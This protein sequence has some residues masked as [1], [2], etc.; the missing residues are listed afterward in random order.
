MSGSSKG[1][2][3]YKLCR[4]PLPDAS[5]QVSKIIGLL[6]LEKKGFKCFAIYSH[7]GHLGH[8]T[9]TIYIN[10]HCPF[11]T[12]LNISF[13]LIGQVVSEKMF[14]YYGHIHVHSPGAGADNRLG[15]NC[16]HKHKSSVH[17]VL[18]FKSYFNSFPHSNAWATYVDLAMIY[19][20]IVELQ[21]PMLHAK[22]QNHRPSGSGE[23]DFKGFCYL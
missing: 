6:G 3:L 23:E 22:F 14:E 16:F 20:N 5:G 18:P 11:L 9:L 8:V 19:K 17:L 21:C 4:G 2:D 10:F 13:A 15:T 1:H 7:G 12:M